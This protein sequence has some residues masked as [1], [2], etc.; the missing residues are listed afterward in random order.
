MKLGP[1]SLSGRW[2][3]NTLSSISDM[4]SSTS[5]Q[6]AVESE[7]SQAETNII[8]NTGRGGRLYVWIDQSLHDN[9][10][11]R[12]DI[13]EEMLKACTAGDTQTLEI[14]LRIV[15]GDM[16]PVSEP[17]PF[18]VQRL[19]ATAI[20]QKQCKVLE[21]LL[22]TYPFLE[23]QYERCLLRLA[24]ENPDLDTFRLLHGRSPDI[25]TMEFEEIHSTSLVEALVNSDPT[26]P[27]FYL[28]NGADVN[29]P[30]FLQVTPLCKAIA[31][32]QPLWLIERM[33]S[34]GARVTR[35]DVRE[36]IRRQDTN[37]LSLV[38]NA[39]TDGVNETDMQTAHETGNKAIITRVE[40]A[41]KDSVNRG[42][43]SVGAAVKAPKKKGT[44]GR[45]WWSFEC[46][47]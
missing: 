10:I 19:V 27:N 41:L 14:L 39:S 38:V 8:D 7:S 22:T 25:V 16:I 17:D 3:F 9:L 2:F 43:P 46:L 32:G 37:I 24:F 18:L 47:K 33:I 40:Q 30:G 35:W 1:T 44:G 6:T 12:N 29:E 15:H 23:I 45:H 20:E 5:S 36:A 31:V 4:A 42:K 28:D 26:I 11:P 34:V 13:E 21:L